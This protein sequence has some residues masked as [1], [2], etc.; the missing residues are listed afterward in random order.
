M[1][2]LRAGSLRVGLQL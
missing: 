1:L 2:R